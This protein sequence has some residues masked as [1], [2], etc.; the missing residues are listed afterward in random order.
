MLKV[1]TFSS[2]IIFSITSHI[3]IMHK[4]TKRKS[5]SRHY[6][7]LAQIHK[8]T[9]IIIETENVAP[10]KRKYIKWQFTK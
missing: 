2:K 8:F 9:S 3:N 6:A 1:Q 4:E 5:N 10:Q 7:G